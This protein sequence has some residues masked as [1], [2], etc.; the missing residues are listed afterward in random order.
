MPVERTLNQTIQHFVSVQAFPASFYYAFQIYIRVNVTYNYIYIL[1]Y[2]I[3]CYDFN[4][5]TCIMNMQHIKNTYDQF[6]RRIVIYKP[7]RIECFENILILCGSHDVG[8]Y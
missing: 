3:L 7:V 6:T 1:K 8:R 4:Y 5:C 2:Y